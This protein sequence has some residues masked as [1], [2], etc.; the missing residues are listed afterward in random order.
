[1]PDSTQLQP[2]KTVLMTLLYLISSAEEVPEKQACT[3]GDFRTLRPFL[4]KASSLDLPQQHAEAHDGGDGGPALLGFRWRREG[5]AETA[6]NIA[7]WALQRH[8]RN[9]V[10]G[11]M[12]ALCLGLEAWVYTHYL[13][14]WP[15]D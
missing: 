14:D 7:A 11:R 6:L 15:S 4:T 8:C 10:Y 12:Q 13:Y 5:T 9:G 2:G 1:M 3:P